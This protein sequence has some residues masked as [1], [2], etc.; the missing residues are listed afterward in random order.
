[1][2]CQ[3]VRN[4][5]LDAFEAT[6]VDATARQR[7]ID[8]HVASCPACAAFAARQQALDG[9]LGALLAP[10][11]LSPAFRAGLRQRMQQD[12]LQTHA[13]P[14]RGWMDAM[15]DILHLASWG[16]A[17]AAAVVMLPFDSGVTAG[18][19]AM[20]A[21]ITYLLLMVVRDTIEDLPETYLR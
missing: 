19:G 18:V 4:A 16:V 1:M 7:T 21:A 14:P 17:T 6:S 13:Q 2:D 20:A 3:Q 10:P 12:A 11:T 9:R 5:I 15:P 8:V